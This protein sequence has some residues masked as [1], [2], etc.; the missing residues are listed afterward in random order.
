MALIYLDSCVVLDALVNPGGRGEHARRAIKS[1]GGETLVISPLVGLECMVRPLRQG[2]HGMIATVRRALTRFRS[3][4]VSPRAYELAAHLRAKHGLKSAD[5]LHVAAASIEHCTA[6]WTSD[7][8]LLRAL[9]DFAVEPVV[10][11]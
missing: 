9:P 10:Y 5:A 4:E 2:D 7:I 1:A 6:L 8:H 11:P 3:V